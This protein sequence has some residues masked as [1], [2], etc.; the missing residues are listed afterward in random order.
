[1]EPLI[2][3]SVCEYQIR[4]LDPEQV[5][6]IEVHLNSWLI[7]NEFQNWHSAS[8]YI[9]ESSLSGNFINNFTAHFYQL[10]VI[11]SQWVKED[12]GHIN[13]RLLGI[14]R[15]VV[16][17]AKAW[18]QNLSSYFYGVV[19]VTSFEE[20][21]FDTVDHLVTDFKVFFGD[22]LVFVHFFD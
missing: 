16:A 22:L 3:L 14:P 20:T 15:A 7:L 1:M 18:D 9:D 6:N 2:N 8:R 12:G 10:V 11:V 5:I 19:L 4:I 21:L 17:G 13:I